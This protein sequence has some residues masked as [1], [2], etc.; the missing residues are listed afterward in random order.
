MD[1]IRVLD[2]TAAP[3]EVDADPG[4]PAGRLAGKTVGIRLDDT[5]RSFQF[6]TAE[7]AERLSAAGAKL[8]WWEAGSRVGE[9]GERTRGEL[10]KFT[11]AVDIAIVGLGN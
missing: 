9:E 11:S 4:P 3:P 5:W 10:E 6:A 8:F 2:P 1:R 7:W